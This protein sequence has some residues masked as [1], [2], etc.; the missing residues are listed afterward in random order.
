MTSNKHGGNLRKLAATAGIAPEEILDFSANINPL[1]PP[2]WMRPLV[3]RMIASLAHYPDPDCA[4]LIKAISA[5]Y[6]VAE[7]E[8]VAG[9]G[10]TELIYLIPRELPVRRAVIPVPAYTDYA[11]ASE[12]AGLTLEKIILKEEDAFRPNLAAIEAR[13]REGDIVFIGQPN[14]PTGLICNA[15]AIRGMALRN[16]SVTFVIDEAFAAFVEGMDSLTQRRPPNVIVLLSFTKFFAIPGLR[17]GCCIADPA[18]IERIKNLLPPWSVNTIAQAIGEKAMAD[19]E[20]ARKTNAYCHA[21]R[22]Y[23]TEQLQSIPGLY[24][25]PGEANYLMVRIDRKGLS[26]PALAEKL[27]P[28]GIAIRVCENFDGLDARFFRVAVRTAEEN[29]I[30]F[31]KLRDVL[32]VTH[33]SAGRKTKPA[34]MIQGTSSNAGKSVM[35]AALCR[36]MLQDGYSVA[37][38]KAQNMSLNSYVTR[39]GGEMGRAQVVQAQACRIDP[40]VRMNPIL[41]KPSSDT[42]AQVIIMGKPVGNMNVGQYISYKPE[43]FTTAKDA[44]DSLASEHD[45]IILEGAGS[46]AEVNLKHHD[47]VNM[48]MARYARSPVILVG[49][50]D[51][52]G[53]FA[54]FVGTMEVLA[55][56]E[57]ALVAGFV[58]NRFRG[59]ESLLDDAINY[60]ERHTGRP[61]FGIVPYLKDLGLPEEDSVTFKNGPKEKTR[62]AGDA[63]E[64]ALI[65]LPHISNFT[66]FD[67]L[68]LE[69]DVH[70][71]VIRSSHDIGR[72]DAVILPGSKNVIGDLDYLRKN[73]LAG[74]I[75]DLAHNGKTEIIGICGG[76]QILGNEIADP[77]G[78]ESGGRTIKGLGL[79]PV[80]TTLAVEKT[81]ECV[82]ARHADSGIAL[83]GYEIHHGLT[84]GMNMPAAVV[85]ADGAVVGV[86]SEDGLLWGT[87]LHGIFDADEF[88]RWFIDRLRTRRG[89]TPVGKLLAA[90][91]LE[92][93]FDRLADIVR[94]RLNMDAIYRLMG[95]R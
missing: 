23:L 4:A 71:R 95:L 37:P 80:A 84:N 34:L 5:R 18:A 26:A 33:I 50:I 38:F 65:D 67:S 15:D 42:G 45:V 30:L 27:L 11:R 31:N 41:L 3:S 92:P 6:G 2:D 29:E 73:G 44:Y 47:I 51:R 79:L 64:I 9:N 53:V 75:A 12:L 70:L 24:V 59:D 88:R 89:L 49:D 43:A 56:W 32:G 87:Y 22:K 81:L 74:R 57:R 8:I 69:P 35:A 52:G 93:A 82:S 63:V 21:E 36:I 28:M 72:P 48:A 16:A 39:D 66:D 60:V 78:I 76:F 62:P 85:R 17:L 25:Y 13:L 94:R 61:T 10:S 19:E 90:Y 7:D 83:K 77:H 1:G 14:N 55:E 46:P 40:D 58:I 54:S 20:Y 91:D 68:R 86:R